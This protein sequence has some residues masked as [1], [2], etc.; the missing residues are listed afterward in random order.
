MVVTP[1]KIVVTDAPAAV[2]PKPAPV[3]LA[4]PAPKPLISRSPKTTKRSL[5][6]SQ[7]LMRQTVKKPAGRHVKVTQPAEIS[8]SVIPVSHRAPRPAQSQLQRRAAA[9]Q[10]SNLISKFA[11][12]SNPPLTVAKRTAELA[13]VAQPAE[14]PITAVVPVAETPPEDIFTKALREATAHTQQVPKHIAQS[15]RRK[16]RLARSSIMGAMAVV[17]LLVIGSVM[18]L[19]NQERNAFTEAAQA[20]GVAATLPQYLPAGYGRPIIQSTPGEVTVQYNSNSDSRSFSISQQNS[21]SASGEATLG[22]DSTNSSIQA[23]DGVTIYRA[24]NLALWTRHGIRFTVSN[25]D[26]F[27]NDQLRDLANSL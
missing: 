27:S 4:K 25:A 5:Q 7:T 9:V 21:V 18:L 15:Q 17:T 19:N 2:R 11:S 24:G 14:P 16:Q 6:H 10:K 3:S 22:T 20:A 8:P 13:V 1:Q 12:L 23:N 26:N